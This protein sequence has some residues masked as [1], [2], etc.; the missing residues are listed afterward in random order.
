MMIITA[1]VAQQLTARQTAGRSS[2]SLPLEYIVWEL[3][4]M[5]T[6]IH[7]QFSARPHSNTHSQKV[8]IHQFKGDHGSAESVIVQAWQLHDSLSARQQACVVNIYEDESWH[9]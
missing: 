6:Y 2:K 4:N 9:P 3:K 5:S 8:G 7:R 1:T